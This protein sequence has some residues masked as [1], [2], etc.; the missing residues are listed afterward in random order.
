MIVTREDGWRSVAIAG[1][2]RPHG[3]ATADH[4]LRRRAIGLFPA[5]RRCG[6]VKHESA[7]RGRLVF[8][9]RHSLICRCGRPLQRV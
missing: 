6:P 8:E 1:S 4:R 7:P 2:G 9:Q 5:P 3:A